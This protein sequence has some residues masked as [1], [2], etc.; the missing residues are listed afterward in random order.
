MGCED[1]NECEFH[2][3]ICQDSSAVCRNIE[4]SFQCLCLEGFFYRTQRRCEDVNEC[5]MSAGICGNGTCVNTIG[6]FHCD[7]HAGFTLHALSGLCLADE[8]PRPS[9]PGFEESKQPP[10]IE[11]VFSC[12]TQVGVCGNGTC[13]DTES[14][15]HCSCPMGEEY[16]ALH[17]ICADIDE[18]LRYPGNCGAGT[19]QNIPGSYKCKCAEGYIFRRKA[20]RCMDMNECRRFPRICGNGRCKNVQGSY[21]CHCSVGQQFDYRT[22]S[23]VPLDTCARN[24]D[25]CGNGTCSFQGTTLECLCPSGYEFDLTLRQCLGIPG[26]AIPPVSSSQTNR[27]TSNACQEQMLCRDGVCIN[28]PDGFMCQCVPGYRLSADGTACEDIDECQGM[29]EVCELGT[30]INQKGSFVCQCQEPLVLDS[31]G[32][33]C[34]ELES[35]EGNVEDPGGDLM[36]AVDMF[37]DT[38]WGRA[39]PANNVCTNPVAQSVSYRQCC[40]G[41]GVGWGSN[42]DPCPPKR[43]RCLQETLPPWF[44]QHPHRPTTSRS[45]PTAG[46]SHAEVKN[47]GNQ[48]SAAVS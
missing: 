11:R 4:G 21:E 25:V 32:R 1:M 33:R 38:C 16:S 6:S 47:A 23:C 24:P 20:S 8:V 14:G 22:T 41:G 2:I 34:I 43:Y 36:E 48:P 37:R 17:G 40:C 7:C 28:T 39:S 18:C 46:W 42:C 12:E 15:Y 44:C 19:C 29:R 35:S 45:G 10:A 13:V 9:L 27:E 26:P 5:E 30:C 3:D 31:S